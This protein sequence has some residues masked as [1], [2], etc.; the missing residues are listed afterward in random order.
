MA[1]V[2]L[3]HGSCACFGLLGLGLGLG[4][5]R[6][7]LALAAGRLLAEARSF[8]LCDFSLVRTPSDSVLYQHTTTNAN[9]GRVY[10]GKRSDP[11]CGLFGLN[12]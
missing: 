5:G 7:Q 8:L 1:I 12:C 9:A 4:L 11:A 2:V 10:P 3:A 6:L